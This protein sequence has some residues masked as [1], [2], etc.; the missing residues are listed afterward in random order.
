[1]RHAE[2]LRFG[3]LVPVSSRHRGRGIEAGIRTFKFLASLRNMIATE[4]PHAWQFDVIF[5]VDA[6]DAVCDPAV[7]GALDLQGLVRA[8]LP[9]PCA[10]SR[11]T[12][13]V[14][15]RTFRHP[16]GHV[17]R[18]WS[19][20]A[21]EAFA[22]G[23]DLVVLLGVDVVLE[24]PGWADAVWDAFRRIADET[25]LP[26]GFGCV[27][28]ADGAFPGFPTFPVL[29]RTHADVFAGRIFLTTFKN[30]DADRSCFS[31]T[32][33]LGQHGLSRVRASPTPSAVQA[34]RDT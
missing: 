16:P 3:L 28:F 34:T 1:M 8:E 21:A 31:C 10:L 25:G 5:G 17:C 20:L 13:R 15:V 29:H 2:A 19:D 11:V 26:F 18:I 27:A 4:S 24:S 23:D 6:G 14:P 32:V 22:S 33:H 12:A 7:E 30:Q 9:L